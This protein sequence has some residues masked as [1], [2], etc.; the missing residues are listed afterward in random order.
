MDHTMK[1]PDV[2]KTFKVLNLIDGGEDDSQLSGIGPLREARTFVSLHGGQHIVINDSAVTTPGFHV[3]ALDAIHTLN[4]TIDI[5]LLSGSRGCSEANNSSLVTLVTVNSTRFLFT[6]D[7]E[8][9]GKLHDC[10]PEIDLLIAR[11]SGTNQLKA[12]VFKVDHHGSDNGNNKA[13]M[14]AIAPKISIISA[15]KPDSAHQGPGGFHAFQFGHPRESAVK[16]IEKGTTTNREPAATVIT[17]D[18]VERIH[19]NRLMKKAVY[20]TCWDG[21][22][23]IEPHTDGSIPTVQVQQ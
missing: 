8:N 11:F 4:P 2:V 9:K 20:C 12:D 7:A 1:L 13:W 14:N 15:G 21:N 10:S 17:M 6:G 16:R 18:G 22:I 23:V 19:N 5:K 3:A